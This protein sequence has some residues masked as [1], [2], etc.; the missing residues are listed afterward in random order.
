MFERE[1]L[2]CSGIIACWFFICDDT[3]FFSDALALLVVMPAFRLAVKRLRCR[4]LALTVMR[5]VPSRA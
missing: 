1:E 3:D 5:C 2:G 4:L